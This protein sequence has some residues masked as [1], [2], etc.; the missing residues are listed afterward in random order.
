MP[1]FTNVTYTI[2]YMTMTD[3]KLVFYSFSNSGLTCFN[4]MHS[5]DPLCE[6]TQVFLSCCTSYSHMIQ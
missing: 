1:L 5:D 2:W 4:V 6:V 3:S